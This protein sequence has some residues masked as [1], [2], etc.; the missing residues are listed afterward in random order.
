MLPRVT[1]K[2]IDVNRP[3]P[4]VLTH[5]FFHSER[6]RGSSLLTVIPQQ[7]EADARNDKMGQ[8]RVRWFAIG[9]HAFPW[10]GQRSTSLPLYRK[11]LI[12]TGWRDFLQDFREIKA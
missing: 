5:Q 1:A 2:A 3:Y 4:R 11:I 6:S 9:C 8:P 7:R 10:R 12:L